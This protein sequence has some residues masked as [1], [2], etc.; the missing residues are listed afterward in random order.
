M[1]KLK[2]WVDVKKLHKSK[3]SKNPNAVEY[4]EKYPKQINWNGFS[5]NP[6]PKAVALLEKNLDKVNWKGLCKNPSMD[7]MRLL[8]KHPA[9]ID[10]DIIYEN[11]YLIDLLELLEKKLGKKNT[12]QM[13]GFDWCKI[14]KHPD[15]FRLASQVSDDSNKIIIKHPYKIDWKGLSENP[16]PTALKLLNKNIDKVDF[17]GLVKNSNPNAVHVLSKF[18]KTPTGQKYRAFGAIKL[19][20]KRCEHPDVVL[21]LSKIIDKLHPGDWARISAN[22]DSIPLLE[23]YPQNINWIE[24]Y[25]NPNAGRL[26]EKHEKS[27]NKIAKIGTIFNVHPHFGVELHAILRNR[28]K[29][30][31]IWERLAKNPNPEMVSSILEK[32]RE[33]IEWK[34]MSENPCIFELDFD[35][36]RKRCGV[37][38]EELIQ[39]TMHPSKIQ[40]LLDMGYEI[41][42]LENLM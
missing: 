29:D 9:R 42:D 39:V 17:E 13:N 28:E 5:E 2:S 40:K 27:L 36:L 23:K 20:H 24:I 11:R 34:Y 33:I 1:F 12:A 14:W 25:K 21:N 7:A 8:A 30:I 37:F 10:W 22:P 32:N 16:H 3:L 31:I 18:L 19:F 6:S 41:E 38:K 15:V 26:I 35:W 4:F